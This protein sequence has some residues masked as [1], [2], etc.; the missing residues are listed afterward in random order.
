MLSYYVMIVHKLIANGYCLLPVHFLQYWE[1]VL[2]LLIFNAEIV[3]YKARVVTINSL[4]MSLVVCLFF[5]LVEQLIFC[6]PSN[7]CRKSFEDSF[8]IK[9]SMPYNNLNIIIVVID[10]TNQ[11]QTSK[12]R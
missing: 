8:R 10:S 4:L 5:L 9:Q 12:S 3:F 7:T 1:N 2:L 6:R 11:S